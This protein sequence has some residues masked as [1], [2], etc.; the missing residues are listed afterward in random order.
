MNAVKKPVAIIL[1]LFMAISVIAVAFMPAGAENSVQNAE[2]ISRD[3]LTEVTVSAGEITYFKFVPSITGK[4]IF[5]SISDEDPYASLFD[6]NLEEITYSDDGYGNDNNFRIVYTLTAGQTYY[7][8]VKYSDES[9]SGL[10]NV[11]L[12]LEC[13]HSGYETDNICDKCGSRI[14]YDIDVNNLVSAPLISKE[15]SYKFVCPKTGIYKISYSPSSTYGTGL[16]DSNGARLE[17]IASGD[18]TQIPPEYQQYNGKGYYALN[19]GETYYFRIIP[20]DEYALYMS[21]SFREVCE[22]VAS[23]DVCANC[24]AQLVYRIEEGVPVQAEIPVDEE[25]T[26]I[27]T[28]PRTALYTRTLYSTDSF[29]AGEVWDYNNHIYTGSELSFTEGETYHFEVPCG[30]AHDL[31]LTAVFKHVH[32]ENSEGR[33]EICGESFL[34]TINLN[35]KLDFEIAPGDM[36]KVVFECPASGTYRF[37]VK[38]QKISLKLKGSDGTNLTYLGNGSD[39]ELAKD[40]V[41]TFSLINS[42]TS[43]ASLSVSLGRCHTATFVADGEIVDKVDFVTGA[44][45][46]NEPEVPEKDGYAGK[47]EAYTLEDSDITVNAVYTKDTGN[48][49]NP[50]DPDN[51]QAVKYTVAFVAGGKTIKKYKLAAGAKITVPP[52]PSKDG[53]TF[54]GWS[55]EV[56]AKMPAKNMTFKAVF[57]CNAKVNFERSASVSYRTKVTITATG[58]NLPKGTVL[59]IYEKGGSKPLTKGNAK[60]VSYEAGEMKSAKTYEVRVID[61]KGNTQEGP[62]GEIKVDVTGTGFFQRIIAFFKYL[63][64]PVPTKTVGPKVK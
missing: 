22:H 49:D 58:E 57:E 56:P 21:V 43:A 55:P 40:V 28:A 37:S 15:L 5:F 54:K 50:D 33:C 8:G 31:A 61:S 45:S 39:I 6:S 1:S 32:V 17:P 10:F 63:F 51:P 64:S 34:H 18:A 52:S 47:W 29:G 16:F 38:G 7:F 24:G 9:M 25:R 44:A 26:F 30:S 53:Y 62:G 11:M 60:S 59:A 48:P 13:N 12:V 2:T 14:I 19:Y 41:Y 23:G 36:H 3:T 20:F 27:F 46:L 42:R 35:E 4:Y